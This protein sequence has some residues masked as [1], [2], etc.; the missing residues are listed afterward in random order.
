MQKPEKLAHEKKRCCALR[1]LNVQSEGGCLG[2]KKL[3]AVA[4]LL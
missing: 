4:L 1:H 3:P 2:R